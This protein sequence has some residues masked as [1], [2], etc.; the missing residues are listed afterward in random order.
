MEDKKGAAIY[1]RVAHAS[2]ITD[3]SAIKM[4]RHALRAF[5]KCEG[6]AVY[7]EYRDNGYGGNTLTRPA[8]AEMETDINAGK[9]ETIIVSNISRIARDIILCQ[10]WINKMDKK[11]VKVIAADNSH[12][13]QSPEHEFLSKMI[14][15]FMRSQ[16]RKAR[17][18]A[19]Q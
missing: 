6:L 3:D 10:D 13:P 18:T 9:I 19:K 17:R 4:Q 5:A 7:K 12:A 8:F 11:G 2:D 1:C 14:T 16:R 15:E